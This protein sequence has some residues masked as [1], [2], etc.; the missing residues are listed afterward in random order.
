MF[1]N[2]LSVT[3]NHHILYAQLR[4]TKSFSARKLQTVK[5]TLT[6]DTG[7]AAAPFAYV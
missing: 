7:R 5:L 4:L 2:D 3:H 6:I 1:Y